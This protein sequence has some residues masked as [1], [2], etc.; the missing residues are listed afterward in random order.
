MFTLGV[1][2]QVNDWLS[3][4][5]D[6]TL[7]NL[8]DIDPVGATAFAPAMLQT[9]GSDDELLYTVQANVADLLMQNS[10]T[11]VGL[12]L[13]D[14]RNTQ[15][16]GLVLGGRYPVTERVRAVPEFTIEQRDFDGLGRQ[17]VY[18]PVLR[19]EVLW[20]KLRLDLELGYEKRSG[21]PFEQDSFFSNIGYQYQF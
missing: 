2:R 9:P 12:R 5:A 11:T 18:R 21:D 10:F 19:F 7:T 20:A 14:G 4:S 8:S 17:W 13:A 1:S 3:L 16:Y 6:A 15:R